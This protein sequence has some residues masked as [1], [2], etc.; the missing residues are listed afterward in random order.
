[1]TTVPVLPETAPFTPAQRAWLNGFFAGLYSRGNAA[2]AAP[3]GAA[4]TALK[5]LSIL[6]ASQTGTAERLAKKASKLAGKRG[7]APTLVEA[8]QSSVEKL[9]GEGPLLLITST[10]GDGEA[11]D[12]AKALL[13]ALSNAPG[14]PLEK[15]RFSVCALGDS[16]YAKF[17]QAGRDFD[18]LLE[19]LGGIRVLER[20]ECDIGQEEVHSVWLDKALSLLT[21]SGEAAN[22]GTVQTNAEESD[23]DEGHKPV[24][25]KLLSVTRL[26]T[27]GSAKEVNHVCIQLAGTGLSYQ[28]GDALSV[29]PTN[30]PAL[31]T[32][33]LG[34]LGCDGEEAVTVGK[35][36]LSLRR[37]L[38]TTQ[39][40]GK[41]S[42]AL[43]KLLEFP[44]EAAPHQVID[45]LVTASKRPEPGAFLGALRRLQPRLY[46]I[47]SSPVAHAG[48][49]HL[50]VGAVR[51]E[52]SGRPRQ[53]LCSTFLAERALEAGKVEISVHSNSGFRLPSKP[54]TPVI[55][56]GP[57]TGIA[58][59]RAFIHE[60]V[61]SG[62]QGENWLFF[63]DQRAATDFLYREELETLEQQGRLR[64]S[65]AW[66]RDQEAKI[67]VQNRMLETAA[68]LWAWLQRGAHFYV[69]GDA[70]RMAKD[71]ESALHR[72]VE[73]A[74][75][76]SPEEAAAYVEEL[77]SSRRYQRDVY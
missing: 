72:V 4:P 59:F 49:V 31:V 35:E 7:F 71:V 55:M 10:Y 62:A 26:N 76:K 33:I 9:G 69:C 54:E 41:P 67:Y 46:S 44:P 15:L 29:M 25:A 43:L 8:S 51:Y 38:E 56:I 40:L 30:H 24:Q 6:F 22:T 74:G 18:R 63:G 17:C 32:E 14:K 60:R 16:N 12:S 77:K 75:G 58:P 3:A 53:G 66:S 50:T 34:L 61:A 39:D 13:K 37:A 48:E 2:G 36:R 70:S 73:T 64:L 28:A 27:Q 1:M 68:E 21:D 52:H 57:G 47:S 65:L 42:P 5:P 20:S 19:K 11:P 45:A 23:D